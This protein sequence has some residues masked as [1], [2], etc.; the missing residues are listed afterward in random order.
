MAPKLIGKKG[1][2]E[3]VNFTKSTP[4]IPVILAFLILWGSSAWALPA[5]TEASG[6]EAEV[7]LEDPWA[8]VTISGAYDYAKCPRCGKKNEVRAESCSGCGY[9]LPQ[10][11]AEVTDPYLV[12]VPGRGYYSEGEIIEPGHTRGWLWVT[13]LVVTCLGAGEVFLGSALLMSEGST[14]ED[15]EGFKAIL[16]FG[17]V[18]LIGGLVMT[19]VGLTH[20]TK[21]VYAFRTGELYEP[22]DGVARERGPVESGNLDFKIE[23]PVLGF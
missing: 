1:E 9:G 5:D 6:G 8:S 3:M 21:P 2:R 15:R 7:A 12:F 10:P 16:I 22:Y 11:S 20:K 18:M 4:Q 19:I 23:V 13:G 14:P 17:G